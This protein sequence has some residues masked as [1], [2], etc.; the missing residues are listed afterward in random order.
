[1]SSKENMAKTDPVCVFTMWLG[2][3]EESGQEDKAE[4][5]EME[6]WKYLADSEYLFFLAATI[7]KKGEQG[8]T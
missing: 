7:Q 2:T 6:T 1:M 8:V 5:W 4:H 3:D